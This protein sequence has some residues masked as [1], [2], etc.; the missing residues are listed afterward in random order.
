MSTSILVSNGTADHTD[1][2]S[3]PTRRSSDLLG[4]A[5]A[6]IPPTIDLNAMDRGGSPTEPPPRR[7]E[8]SGSRPP[9]RNSPVTVPIA[10]AF[11]HHRHQENHGSR[12]A[13]VV[14]A[15]L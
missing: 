1:L 13:L 14:F 7:S 9:H 6:R 2:N 3:F 10:Q 12:E 11:D 5:G 4:V 8:I 15:P